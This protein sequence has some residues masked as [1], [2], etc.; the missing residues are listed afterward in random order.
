[1]SG[2]ES[3]QEFLELLRELR[4]VVHREQA[5]LLVE[6]DRDRVAL[7]RLGLP[8]VAILLVHHGVTLSVLVVTVVRRGRTVII[9]TDWDRSGGE[10]AHRLR[11]LFDDG[12]IRFDLDFRRRMARAV[13]GE[14]QYVEA[15]LPWAERAA[16]RAGAPLEHWLGPP[17]GS[18][19]GVE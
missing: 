10:L 2:R 15:L 8:P 6:G 11:S 12:R 7:R 3:F 5:V 4:E 16:K 9:L 13:R 19:L 18:A 17:L 1:M 14:T